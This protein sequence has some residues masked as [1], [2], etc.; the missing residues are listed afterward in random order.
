MS[1]LYAGRSFGAL[2]LPKSYGKGECCICRAEFDRIQKMQV[3]C[4][5]MSCQEE[6]ERQTKK[7][8]AAKRRSRAGR[9]K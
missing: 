9:M 4:G 2:R 5:K 8:L 3:T 6:R 1:Y 7:R